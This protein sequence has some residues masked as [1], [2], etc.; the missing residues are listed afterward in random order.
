MAHEWLP[1][2]ATCK[3]PLAGG[4]AASLA[5]QHISAPSMPTA[6]ARAQP[7]L[8]CVK[9]P[10]GG[11]SRPSVAPPQHES[12]LSLLI[13][14]PSPLLKDRSVNVPT[15]GVRPAPIGPQQA[16][17]PSVFNPQAEITFPYKSWSTITLEYVPAGAMP[18]AASLLEQATDPSVLTPHAKPGL[19]ADTSLYA[20]TGGEL[21]VKES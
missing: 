11:V 4:V 8:T 12:V 17:V 6:Q 21:S 15:G 5:P 7:T 18:V 2:A 9:I 13:A 20:P 19:P 14:H 10:A 16:I 3:T 1:P